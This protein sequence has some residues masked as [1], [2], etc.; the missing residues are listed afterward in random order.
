M[1]VVQEEGGERDCEG[2]GKGGKGG[3]HRGRGAEQ[4]AVTEQD[5]WNELES[6]HEAGKLGGRQ[7]DLPDK[8]G[9]ARGDERIG[10]DGR[11]TARQRQ[12]GAHHRT[13]ETS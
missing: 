9:H 13:G 12:A 8:D 6:V 7:R 4:R 1:D 3:G 5:P 10:I 11:G 2:S